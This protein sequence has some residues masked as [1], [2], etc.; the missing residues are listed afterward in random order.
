[1]YNVSTIPFSKTGY[2]SK[3]IC[4]YLNQVEKL[5]AFYGEYSDLE[6]FK[7]QIETKRLSFKRESRTIL[8]NALKTQYKNTKPSDKTL[9]N[10]DSLKKENTFT[11]TTG[12]QLNLFT[13]PLYF[14]YKIIST[15]NLT[16]ELKKEKPDSNFVPVYWMATEDHDF[17]EIQYFNFKGKKVSWN[18]ESSG[19]VGRLST[20]GLE[21][22]LDEFSK[23]I[24]DSNSAKQLKKLFSDAYL[25]HTNLTTAT[26]YLANKLFSEYGL[27]IVDGDDI[28]LKRM[29]LPYV[30]QEL[31][32]QT[33]FTEVSKTIKDLE[34]NYKVQVNPREINLFY[35]IDGLRERIILENDLYKINNTDIEFSL[36]ELQYE[37][38]LHPERFSPNVIMR[39][40]Y[41]EVIL[42][43]LCYIG[44][45]GELAYWF[46]LKPYFES[47][48]VPFPILLLRNSAVVITEK[49]SKTLKKLNI[50]QD[51]LFL[52]QQDLVN[53]KI[54]EHSDLIIDFSEQR[55]QIDSHFE[56]L[57]EI[58]TQTDKSFIGAVKA[59]KQKQ[60]NGL[61]N[62]EKRLLKAERRKYKDLT[63]RI[64]EVQDAIFPKQSLQERNT[65]FSEL[66]LEYGEELIPKLK[67]ALKP[68][69]L[70]FTI[71]E[72]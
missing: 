4:D 11:I 32:K 67:E 71:I 3:T 21:F 7:N 38:K 70:E 27:V 6:G 54:T 69:D 13:G 28:E 42:P 48:D 15:I 20:E 30:E 56:K 61:D 72:M 23:L 24:G 58:A 59:Q 25:G 26:R 34:K 19:G 40:L 36:D 10:I 43:N 44:G 47:V 52:K 9:V 60:L 35:L 63:A 37:L 66:Y 41:Q 1:M 50:S 14:L 2:F 45:G 5:S 39:P 53:K 33:A 57:E 64:K 51:E 62:L 55:Q 49:Q 16:E 31:F 22:V 8:I 46:E 29:F 12:H 17:E 68:L 65:N 18:R